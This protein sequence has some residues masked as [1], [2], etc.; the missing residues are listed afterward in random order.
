MKITNEDNMELMARYPDNHFELAIV[1]PPYGIERFKKCSEKD[2]DTKSVHAK[3]FQKM[4][5]VNDTKPSKKYWNE[6]FR[7]SKNQIVL[8]LIILHYQK[9]NI[10]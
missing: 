4:G 10:F 3:R 8:V 6:L 2:L 7:V 9:V 5:L 1:D